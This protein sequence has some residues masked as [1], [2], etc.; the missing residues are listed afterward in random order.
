[1]LSDEQALR[2][3]LN[4]LMLDPLAGGAGLLHTCW[5]YFVSNTLHFKLNTAEPPPRTITR[6]STLDLSATVHEY[7]GGGASWRAKLATGRERAG[8]W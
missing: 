6:T 4:A 8:W 2:C 1:M 5:L 3:R 7:A